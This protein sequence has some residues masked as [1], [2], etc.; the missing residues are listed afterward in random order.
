MCACAHALAQ[1]TEKET[2][3][4]EECASRAITLHILQK[5]KKV[6][7]TAATHRS[8]SRVVLFWKYLNVSLTRD[9][10]I[11]KFF[12]N[13]SKHALEHIKRAPLFFYASARALERRERETVS[14]SFSSSK[15]RRERERERDLLSFSVFQSAPEEKIFR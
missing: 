1:R 2:R 7:F 5:E 3:D 9:A 12:T 14:S 6:V 15:E 10:W 11:F 4:L 13:A 8:I